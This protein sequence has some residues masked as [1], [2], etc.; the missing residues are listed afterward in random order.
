MGIR[1]DV[2][3]PAGPWFLAC[4][5]VFFFHSAA[6][7]ADDAETAKPEQHFDV[8]EYRVIGNTVLTNRDIERTLYPLLGANKTIK[9]LE[10][11]RT[12]LE[13]LYHD[14]GYG[15]VFVD[16]PPQT[17][18]GGLVRLRVTEGR[19]ESERISGAHYFPERDVI[20]ALP[21]AKP[22]TV[23]QLSKLQDELA[24]VNTETPDRS[25][26]PVLKAGSAPGTVDLA[27]QVNDHLPLHG[28]LEVNNQAS[29]DTRSLRSIASVSYGDLFGRFD[30]FSLQY[31]F[32][33]QQYDQVRVFAANYLFHPLESGLQP[34]LQYINSNSNVAAVGTLGVLGTGEITGLRL[35]YPFLTAAGS[36]QSVTLGLDYKHFRNLINQNA[37]TADDTPIT[38]L[39]LS[40]A[41][42][43]LWRSDVLTTTFSLA[44]NAGPRG[45]VNNQNAF[46]ND[47]D[48]GRDNYFYVRGDL[49]FEVKLPADFRIRVRA[50][51]QAA[52]E[53]L[54]TNE[55]FSIAGV[56]GV[57][58]YL[59][60][61]VLG[62][63]GLKE[64]VQL[65]SPGWHAHDRVLG[66][67]FA[68]FDAGRTWVIDSLACEPSGT[69]LHLRS[70]GGGFDVLPGQKITGSFTYARAL[71]SA[72]D[73]GAVATAGCPASGPATLAGQ[74]RVLFLLRGS[75]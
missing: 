13:T 68:F 27:L 73:L 11:A 41:Y 69:G 8:G 36:N 29:L 3:G 60:S 63:E 5:L 57:R 51:G 40:F 52:A 12:A 74:S 43:G 50:A 21:A 67:A 18:N 55:N 34:S 61:E 28:S 25:V 64:T 35:A 58:G 15:T 23:L 46:A 6:F 59:E 17:V 72:T 4:V 31:Q 22:G 44:A 48:E 26:V 10:S 30:T 14:R 7:A 39:N 53:P 37:T 1:F 66:D 42:A 38:Y 20:A 70:V 56:D 24:A 75:F 54:I 33:P 19:V 49:A 47:R 65:F 62:D 32:T 2:H 71:D 16:I 45:A 9:D